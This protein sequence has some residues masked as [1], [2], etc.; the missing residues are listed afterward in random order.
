M[1]LTSR[2]QR[3][4]SHHKMVVRSQASAISTLTP[5]SVASRRSKPLTDNG[6]DFTAPSER[7]PAAAASSKKNIATPSTTSSRQQ[8]RHHQNGV[9]CSQCASCTSSCACAGAQLRLSALEKQMAKEHGENVAAQLELKRATREI[10][11]LRKIVEERLGGAVSSC[12]TKSSRASVRSGSSTQLR[13]T[14][15]PEDAAAV[16]RAST[17]SVASSATVRTTSSL[18]APDSKR[19]ASGSRSSGRNS[20]TPHGATVAPKDALGSIPIPKAPSRGPR[21]GQS[22]PGASGPFTATPELSDARK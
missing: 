1:N 12:A 3:R 7:Q 14:P 19:S 16:A 8:H 6:T 11:M 9:D 13:A 4:H 22:S 20:A 21:S 15:G 5:S 10:E 2:S 17:E 18:L